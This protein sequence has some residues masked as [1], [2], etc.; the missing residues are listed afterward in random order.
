MKH[1]IAVVLL[2][3]CSPVFSQLAIVTAQNEPTNLDAIKKQLTHYHACSE[4]DCYIPQIEEQIDIAIAY[5][6][7]SVTRAKPG[8][9]LALVLDID[10]TALS[11]WSVENHDDFGYISNDS[12]WCVE[13][14]CGTAI[15]GTLRLYREAQRDNVTVFFITGRPETQRADTEANLK[16]VGY[17]RFERVY[18]R[19]VNYPG[20]QSIAEYKSE[21]RAE[22]LKMGFRITLNVGDQLSDL[23]GNPQADHSVKL[24]NPFYFIP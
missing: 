21:Q 9:K 15:A 2:L 23:T 17:D 16:T 5:L 6:R 4:P 18:M 19:P 22:I 14:R 20:D 8:E 24:P 10:E 1:S 3:F 11:N 7:E 13:L 12:N